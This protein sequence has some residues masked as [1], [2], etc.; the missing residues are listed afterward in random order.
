[1]RRHECRDVRCLMDAHLNGDNAALRQEVRRIPQETPID[2]E[3]VC[4]A[5]KC[6]MRLVRLHILHQGFYISRRDIRRIGQDHRIAAPK[7]RSSEVARQYLDALRQSQ[8]CRVLC[9]N[10]RGSGRDVHGICACPLRMVQNGEHDCPRPRADIGK[11]QLPRS[12]LCAC[13]EGIHGELRQNLRIGTRDE[14]IA[15]DAE[16]QPH[17]LPSAQYVGHRDMRPA[18]LHIAA[19][20]RQFRRLERLVKM[21]IEIH[22]IPTEHGSEQHFGIETRCLHAA[23]AKKICRPRQ[24]FLYRPYTLRHQFTC[25]RRSA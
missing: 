19:K 5:V 24:Q 25:F 8:L 7:E 12:R 21:D 11:A 20:R 22:A 10:C 23:R 17:E 18:L 15:R 2:G 16:G 6:E 14:R 13:T 9:G 4:S 1:M 3:P